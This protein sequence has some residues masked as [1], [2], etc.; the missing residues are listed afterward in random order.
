MVHYC[1]SKTPSCDP[2][3]TLNLFD[4][5][6]AGF[7]ILVFVLPPSE[8]WSPSKVWSQYSSKTVTIQVGALQAQRLASGSTGPSTAGESPSIIFV[9]G[10]RAMIGT[11]E[12]QSSTAASRGPRRPSTGRTFIWACDEFRA[13]MSL[14]G[15]EQHG[16]AN[17]PALMLDFLSLF[18]QT[19][20]ACADL[21]LGWPWFSLESP[22]LFF[23]GHLHSQCPCVPH[24]I[25][26]L[27]EP[28][29]MGSQFWLRLLLAC[30]RHSRPSALSNGSVL[31]LNDRG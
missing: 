21:Q 13:L 14:R 20:Q 19:F 5:L 9:V 18:Q 30:F 3:H 15:A 16:Y 31:L 1:F 10:Q 29:L 7:F 6:R 11:P 28:T 24:T 8:T 17:S 2:G 26:L 4:R 23:Q 27:A 25:F 22:E 12:V